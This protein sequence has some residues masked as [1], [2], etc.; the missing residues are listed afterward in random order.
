MGWLQ[1]AKYEGRGRGNPAEAQSVI[2]RAALLTT[3]TYDLRYGVLLRT[4]D[5]SRFSSNTQPRILTD[6]F[7]DLS[8]SRIPSTLKE[9]RR[10]GGPCGRALTD[11]YKWIAEC[12]GQVDVDKPKKKK[13][14]KLPPPT[15][16]GPA[17]LSL[18]L[19]LAKRPLRIDTTSP[20]VQGCLLAPAPAPATATAP[21]P[22]SLHESR[23]RPI[24][25]RHKRPWLGGAVAE[26]SSPST[27]MA[28]RST[29]A[30]QA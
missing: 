9:K 27:E 28:M 17:S 25:R 26:S 30:G 4:T 23:D 14:T 20:P 8:R 5:Q 13:K 21:H 24:E 22:P 15:C 6:I 2:V 16:L 18:T 3:T 29:G 11:G 1:G 19:S 12:Q 10:T 7:L